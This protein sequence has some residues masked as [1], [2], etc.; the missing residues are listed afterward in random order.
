MFGF[1]TGYQL[2]HIRH[3]IKGKIIFY[4]ELGKVTIYCKSQKLKFS[5]SFV[6]IE[7]KNGNFYLQ[8]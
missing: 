4:V 6:F 5:A 7:C 1:K 8:K 3:L 2:F